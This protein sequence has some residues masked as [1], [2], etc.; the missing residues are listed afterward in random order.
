[1]FRQGV[2]PS[3]AQREL[4]EISVRTSTTDSAAGIERADAAI[5]REF[6]WEHLLKFYCDVHRQHKIAQAQYRAFNNEIK[7]KLHANL[8]FQYAQSWKLFSKAWI[9]FLKEFMVVYVDKR[10]DDHE[11]T[12]DAATRRDCVFAKYGGDTNADV[13]QLDTDTF[14]HR[15]MIIS[16]RSLFNGDFSSLLPVHHCKV[17]C[18]HPNRVSRSATLKNIGN[19]IISQMSRPKQWCRERWLGIDSAQDFYGLL[20]EAH[21]MLRYVFESAFCQQ[22]FPDA[23]YQFRDRKI[24][25]ATARQRLLQVTL[26][27]P[28]GGGK[29][30]KVRK[31]GTGGKGGKDHGKAGGKDSTGGK[32]GKDHG[33]GRKAGGKDH[34]KAGGKGSKG[35]KGSSDGKTQDDNEDDD[36]IDFQN[37]QLPDPQK[38]DTSKE[39]AKTYRLNGRRWLR[40]QPGG[41]MWVLRELPR[42]QQRNQIQVLKDVGDGYD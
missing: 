11:L 28:D 24:T 15:K 1:L 10:G 14:K 38:G 5:S 32:G 26:D 17:G 42:V 19:E 18:C 9:K 7:G 20:H 3:Q 39:R 8:S 23:L 13:V 30:G 41:R 34:G 2:K 33:K 6:P 12:R 40:S 37:M 25:E 36:A 4:Y 31:D 27:R 22:P 16:F 35:D 21:G 29:G